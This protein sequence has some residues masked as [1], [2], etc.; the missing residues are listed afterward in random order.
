MLC[1]PVTLDFASQLTSFFCACD[2]Y[3]VHAPLHAFL[4]DPAGQNPYRKHRKYMASPLYAIERGGS[5][6]PLDCSG[7]YRT[8][9]ENSLHPWIWLGIGRCSTGQWSETH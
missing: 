5:S 4:E 3:R 6:D 8:R 1:K 2:P 9:T 7:V